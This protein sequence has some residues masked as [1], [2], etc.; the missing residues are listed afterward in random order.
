MLALKEKTLSSECEVR[1]T[2]TIAVTPLAIQCTAQTQCLHISGCSFR[3]T[4]SAG[5]IAVGLSLRSFA[6]ALI[7]FL[8]MMS[9]SIQRIKYYNCTSN[10]NSCA[11]ICVS[12]RPFFFICN[13]KCPQWQVCSCYV[14]MATHHAHIYTHCDTTIFRGSTPLL[15]CQL[16]QT[17]NCLLKTLYTLL[18]AML[19]SSLTRNLMASILS[20]AAALCHWHQHTVTH[21][22]TCKPVCTTWCVQT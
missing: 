3:I 22:Y 21:T 15:P 12:A 9:L 5:A 2:K 18:I 13:R 11:H 4:S 17:A 10:N 7:L 16:K 8:S 14:C 19:S 6:H 20:C 1:Q